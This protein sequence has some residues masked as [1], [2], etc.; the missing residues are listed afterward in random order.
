MS[1]KPPLRVGLLWHSL[2]SGNLGVG[3]LTASNIA[4]IDG[5]AAELGRSIEYHVVGPREPGPIYIEGP[6]IHRH[7][8]TTRNMIDPTRYWRVMGNVDCVIDIGAGDS[9]AGIYGAKRFIFIWLTKALALLRGKPL[10]LAP[11]TIGPFPK[12][13]WRWLAGRVMNWA[14]IVIARDPMSFE[15]IGEVAPNAKRAQAIDVAFRLPFTRPKKAGEKLRVGLNV[16]GLLYHGGYGRKNDFGLDVNYV[17]LTSGIIDYFKSHDDVQLELITHVVSAE[18]AVDDDAH[19]A[20]ALVKDHPG[21]VRV[22]DFA[23]PSDAKSHVSGLDFLIAGRM[24]ACIAAYSSGVP[25]IP[26]A[27]SRK[28]AGLFEGVL[29]YRHGIPVTGVTTEQAV[30]YVTERFEKR[31]ELKQEIETG[32]TKVDE[33]MSRYTDS[34]KSFFTSVE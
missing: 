4:I 24:H 8:I 9:F 21:L 29:G 10:M 32:L 22:P 18:Q 20:D 7:L 11:Q 26:V 17:D 25:V 31:A 13:P 5:V 3:A 14:S 30:A 6:N 2:N 19:I 34:L 12:Q 27:Y 15:A 23:S 1:T 33:A 16:S 28:F